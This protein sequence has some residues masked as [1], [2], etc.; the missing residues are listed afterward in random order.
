M[1]DTTPTVITLSGGS[2]TNNGATV[3]FIDTSH[4]GQNGVFALATS[5]QTIQ[6][7]QTLPMQ[8]VVALPPILYPLGPMEMPMV[9]VFFHHHQTQLVQIQ[10]TLILVQITEAPAM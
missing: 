10:I 9:F 2:W 5:P 1:V 8:G 7:T 3:N 6:V 4:G